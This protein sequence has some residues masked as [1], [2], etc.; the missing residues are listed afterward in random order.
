MRKLHAAYD[1][2]LDWAMR[3]PLKV[4]GAAGAGLIAA[5][6]AFTGIGSTFMP[7]MDEGTPVVTVRKHPTIGVADAADTD[8]RI[9]RHIKERVP[10]VR[11][12][13]ARA[14]ADSSASTPSG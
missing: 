7:T 12:I 1:P 11:G 14:G 6:V 2:F 5:G 4:T 9:Q 8:L 13:M 10:E 3:N